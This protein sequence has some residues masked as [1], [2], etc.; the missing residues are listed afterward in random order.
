ME[1][2]PPTKKEKAVRVPILKSQPDSTLATKK[3]MPT[4]KTTRKARHI[5]YSAARKAFAPAWMSR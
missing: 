2:M 3:I 4:P 5:L 1:V